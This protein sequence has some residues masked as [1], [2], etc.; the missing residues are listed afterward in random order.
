MKVRCGGR[1]VVWVEEG[2]RLVME[3]REMEWD[4]VAEGPKTCDEVASGVG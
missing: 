4:Q 3:R 1:V 2:V